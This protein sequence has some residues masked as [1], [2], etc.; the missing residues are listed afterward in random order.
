[1]QTKLRKNGAFTLIE[2]MI[3]VLIL[4]ILAAL[5]VPRLFQNQDTAKKG[6]AVADIAELSNALG[7]FRVDNDRFPTDQEGLDALMTAPA[8]LAHWGPDKYIEKLPTDP[9]DDAYQYKDLG[10]N[11]I[12]VRSLGPDKTPNTD[13]DITN[14]DTTAPK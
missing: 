5:I 3:V 12:E 10:N 14:N 1:M 6:K 2:L 11:Q 8:D 9:W 13:D 7:R 4:G